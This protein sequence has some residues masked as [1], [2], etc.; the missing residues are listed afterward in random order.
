MYCVAGGSLAGLIARN[1]KQ[2]LNMSECELK[3]VLIQISKGLLY[4]HSQNLV[5][6]DIKPGT[7]CTML[8]SE[9]F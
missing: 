2:G 4:I 1:H 7:F 5:H 3:Q 8:S 6:L 9:H